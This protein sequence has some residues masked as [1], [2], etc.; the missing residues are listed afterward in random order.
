MLIGRP[1]EEFLSIRCAKG[2][3]LSSL[4]G[5][6]PAGGRSGEDHD[7]AHIELQKLTKQGAQ[8]G[9]DRVDVHD[10]QHVAMR[11]VFVHALGE[12]EGALRCIDRRRRQREHPGVGELERL[13]H[14]LLR[15]DRR[16][17]PHLAPTFSGLNGNECADLSSLPVHD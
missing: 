16:A 1:N 12:Q 9:A 7:I 3:E 8:S 15:R 17:L 2:A 13:G 4:I 10:E 6:E 11:R 5:R 14:E